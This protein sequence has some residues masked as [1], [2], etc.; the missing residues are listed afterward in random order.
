MFRLLKNVY[1][2][3]VDG[4]RNMTTGRVLWLIIAIKVFVL[5]AVLRAFFFQ[6][7]LKGSPEEKQ[8]TVGN[9]LSQPAQ[10]DS[11]Q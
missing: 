10:I 11:A 6:P 7:V 2:F 4:F 1:R 5:F 9:N 8:H 3:Y